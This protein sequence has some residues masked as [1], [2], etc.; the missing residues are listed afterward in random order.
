MNTLTENAMSSFTCF[1]IKFDNTTNGKNFI[2][3]II[4]PSRYVEDYAGSENQLLIGFNKPQNIETVGNSF[5]GISY[6]YGID[7]YTAVPGLLKDILNHKNDGYISAGFGAEVG[8]LGIYP[9]PS[10]YT[11]IL[12]LADVAQMSNTH[13]AMF[14]NGHLYQGNVVVKENKTSGG[15]F[16]ENRDDIISIG[17]TIIRTTAKTTIQIAKELTSSALT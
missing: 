8:K 12:S 1:Y 17:K 11:P 10:I 5:P 3:G 2:D 7:Y 15:F 13:I 4:Y 16:K 9:L 14:T 6:I